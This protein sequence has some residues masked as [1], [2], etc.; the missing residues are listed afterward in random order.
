M[1]PIIFYKSHMSYQLWMRWTLF[2]TIELRQDFANLSWIFHGVDCNFISITNISPQVL[3]FHIFFVSLCTNTARSSPNL[4]PVTIYEVT[5]SLKHRNSRTS[6]LLA[7]NRVSSD[8]YFTSESHRR[9]ASHHRDDD[10][11]RRIVVLVDD[12]QCHSE[13]ARCLRYS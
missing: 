1:V 11:E 13:F 12:S 8:E 5:Q 9:R 7:N 3:Q 6:L 2:T 10:S 4:N